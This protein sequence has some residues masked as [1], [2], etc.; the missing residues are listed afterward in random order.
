MP[1]VMPSQAASTIGELFSGARS[2]SQATYSPGNANAL[3]GILAVVRQV[4]P[5]LL[6]LPPDRYSELVLALG[7]I[8]Q[9]LDLWTSRG[10]VGIL[11]PIKGLD[12][13]HLLWRA[14]HACPDEYPP[15]STTDLAFIL[16]TKLQASIRLDIGA[17]TRALQ[18]N[19]WKAATVLAGAT[20]E[21]LLHW[22]LNEAPYPTQ[23]AGA[24]KVVAAAGKLKGPPPSDFDLWGL[25]HFIEVAGALNVIKPD[26]VKAADL[27]R[28]FRNLIHPGA[29]ARKAAT[30]DRATA[31]SAVAGMENV[32][33]DLT[34]P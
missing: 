13:L 25:Q 11:Q 1:T 18:N 20:I 19:E 9:Q 17:A 33:R 24:G 2:P 29:A 30:C 28:D 27:A 12:V 26:T 32:I 22:K 4:P 14:L 31:Y 21:A 6:V 8:E 5:E 15:T 34:P 7:A 3:R 10:E 16:D 23:R